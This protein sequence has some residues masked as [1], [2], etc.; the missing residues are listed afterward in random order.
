MK[1]SQLG[2]V[3][4]MPSE[5]LLRPE[6]EL[7]VNLD[8]DFVALAARL[9]SSGAEV[10]A[11]LLEGP[12]FRC[13]ESVGLSKEFQRLGAEVFWV[14]APFQMLVKCFSNASEGLSF[15]V[16]WFRFRTPLMRAVMHYG[17]RGKVEPIVKE[18]HLNDI[19]Y[20][21]QLRHRHSSALDCASESLCLMTLENEYVV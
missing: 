13:P 17:H 6:N 3:A 14:Q 16:K 5:R 1:R 2:T 11:V 19:F 12:A 20:T 8:V 4:L 7:D 21:P 10:V 9:R 18:R 15:K